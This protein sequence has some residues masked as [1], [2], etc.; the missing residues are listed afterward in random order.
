M[1]VNRLDCIFRIRLLGGQKEMI[2]PN[3][4]LDQNREFE[5]VSPAHAGMY[6][7]RL[8]YTLT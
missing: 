2:H 4:F 8:E 3:S 5:E 6:R 1:G 7:V